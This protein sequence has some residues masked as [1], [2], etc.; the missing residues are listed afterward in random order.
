[1]IGSKSPW[2]P[3]TSFRMA[4]CKI[5]W[6]KFA[7]TPRNYIQWWS[8]LGYWTCSWGIRL[9]IT[10]M[11]EYMTIL[12]KLYKYDCAVTYR[13]AMYSISPSS[14]VEFISFVI[15]YPTRYFRAWKSRNQARETSIS[16]AIDTGAKLRS[17]WSGTTT[18]SRYPA[19]PHNVSSTLTRWALF[20]VHRSPW[21]WSS[22]TY[23]CRSHFRIQLCRKDDVHEISGDH[24]DTRTYGLLRSR[25]SRL[26]SSTRSNLHTFRNVRRY[27]RERQHIQSRNDRNSFYP[28]ESDK[29]FARACR[30]IGSRYSKWWRMCIGVE[31][32]WEFDCKRHLH[33]FC[34]AFPP[35]EWISEC[36]HQLQMLPFGCLFFRGKMC[37]GTLTSISLYL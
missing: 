16:G 1:M 7:H 36:I 24:H 26:S 9:T 14:F 33:L 37:F 3:F 12:W 25:R 2:S 10:T 19:T 30:W 11:T 17:K 31:Y 34:N 28:W 18:E 8:A 35:T 5:Y 4:L 27:G 22:L 6:R 21:L 29:S 23:L 32:Q 20:M 13:E 15:R